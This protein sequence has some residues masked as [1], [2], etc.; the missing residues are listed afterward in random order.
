MFVDFLTRYI[1]PPDYRYTIHRCIVFT[2]EWSLIIVDVVQS[3]LNMWL[4]MFA[5]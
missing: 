2:I 3:L 4:M 1:D 5:L